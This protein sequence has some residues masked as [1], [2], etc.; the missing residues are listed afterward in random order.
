MGNWL[1]QGHLFPTI[2]L[3][4]VCDGW[5]KMLTKVLVAS[6]ANRHKAF[7][8]HSLHDERGGP[9]PRALA[10]TTENQFVPAA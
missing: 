3:G 2:S 4:P 10:I 8:E 5:P 9:P 7:G 1:R 6:L